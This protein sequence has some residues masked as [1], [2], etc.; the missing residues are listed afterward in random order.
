MN[1]LAWAVPVGLY[2][3]CGGA[4]MLGRN[5]AVDG[6]IASCLALA[7]AGAAMIFAKVQRSHAKLER[8]DG[9]RDQ[10]ASA[11]AGAAERE[12]HAGAVGQRDRRA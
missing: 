10:L 12:K 4:L 6:S 11:R 2:A 5:E 8:R 7:F 3:M 1:P 9:M